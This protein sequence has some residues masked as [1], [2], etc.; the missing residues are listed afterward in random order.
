MKPLRLA[1]L[2]IAAAALATITLFFLAPSPVA[3]R[4]A[5]PPWVVGH[6]GHHWQILG[7]SLQATTPA[8]V[9]ARLGSDVQWA[10]VLRPGHPFALEGWVPDFAAQGITG[11]LLLHFALPEPLLEAAAGLSTD[12][13]RPLPNGGLSRPFDPRY[14]DRRWTTEPLLV[15]VGFIPGALLDEPTL[16]ARFAPLGTPER[17]VDSAGDTHLLYALT[18]PDPCTPLGI[19]LVIPTNRG[20]ALIEYATY[21]RLRKVVTP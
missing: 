9:G 7:W 1:L 21:E 12:T 4:S 5:P 20:R 2:V 11:K 15:Q 3:L 17:W 13:I 8:E 10:I 16:T 19:H 6:D 14:T 18:C